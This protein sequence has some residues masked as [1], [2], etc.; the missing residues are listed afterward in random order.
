MMLVSM[1]DPVSQPLGACREDR[2]LTRSGRGACPNRFA[3]VLN[4]AGRDWSRR[5]EGPHD[6]GTLQPANILLV[7]RG[8]DLFR[9]DGGARLRLASAT[10][11][12]P[13]PRA[14][15]A[16]QR[17]IPHHTGYSGSLT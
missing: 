8:F 3:C 6:I 16:V 17:P 5:V 1:S 2:A 14:F 12:R 10:K 7:K 11:R 4:R 13:T 9:W 15:D